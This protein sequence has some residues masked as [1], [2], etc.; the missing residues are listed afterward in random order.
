[1]VR[2]WLVLVAISEVAS[3]DNAMDDRSKA[4]LRC[5]DLVV[6]AKLVVV[7]TG[8]LRGRS[9]G[10]ELFAGRAYAS[11]WCGGVPCRVSNGFQPA[12]S[13][14]REQQKS[15][16]FYITLLAPLGPQ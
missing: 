8:T 5:R 9:S 7:E 2:V 4:S 15:S 3:E 16:T 13:R 11:Q 10:V 14:A 6:T 12:G 1:M